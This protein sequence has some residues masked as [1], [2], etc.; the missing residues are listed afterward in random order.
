[1]CGPQTHGEH[2]WSKAEDSGGS[3]LSSE[4]YIEQPLLSLRKKPTSSAPETGIEW[5]LPHPLWAQ[6]GKDI[7]KWSSYVLMRHA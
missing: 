2:D 6:S 4:A 1:M 7:L 5:R 3:F